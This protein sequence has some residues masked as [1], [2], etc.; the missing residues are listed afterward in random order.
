VVTNEEPPTD[1][2]GSGPKLRTVERER[3]HAD[4]MSNMNRHDNAAQPG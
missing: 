3:E 2:N 1:E 4:A